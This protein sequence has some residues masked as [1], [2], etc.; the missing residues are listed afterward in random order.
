MAPCTSG[1][2]SFY[3]SHLAPKLYDPALSVVNV[4]SHET[5]WS[6]QFFHSVMQQTCHHLPPNGYHW[7]DY[8]LNWTPVSPITIPN[9]TPLYSPTISFSLVAILVEFIGLKCQKLWWSLGCVF[10]K[11]KPFIFVAFLLHVPAGW[12][13]RKTPAKRLNTL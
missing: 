6:H 1:C 12:N 2:E 11:I 3:C 7:Y 8:R 13:I 5:K 4:A 9:W 10:K